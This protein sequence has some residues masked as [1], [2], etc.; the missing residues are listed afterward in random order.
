MVAQK[1]KLQITGSFTQTNLWRIALFSMTL[2]FISCSG[3]KN[4]DRPVP[5]Y[6]VEG[7]FITVGDGTKIFIYEYVPESDFKNTIYIISGITGIN[8]NSEKDIIELLSNNENRV[9]VIHPRGTGYSEGTRG[10][11]P[12]ISEFVGDYVEIIKGD[13]YIVC[14]VQFQYRF[15][16]NCK[17]QMDLYL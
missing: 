2:L 12:D 8:H 15:P 11:I 9:V 4:F 7:S 16:S 17:K 14:R 13:S 5:E 6:N 10:D 3:M 1:S